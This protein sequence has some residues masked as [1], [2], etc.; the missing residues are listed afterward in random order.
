MDKFIIDGG[1]SLKGTITISGS[2]NASLPILLSTLLTQEICTIHQVPVSRDINTTIRLLEYL[3]KKVER[4]GHSIKVSP[5]RPLKTYAPYDLV[6]QMRASVLVAGPLLARFKKVR[7]P[8]PGGCAIGLR[9]IN[10]HLEGFKALGA[11][12]SYQ[13]GDVILKANRLKGASIKLPFPSVGATENLLMSSVLIPGRTRIQNAAREPEI[14]DLADFL[15]RM[16]AKIRGA[17]K[18]VIHIVGVKELHG[19]WH[20][21]IPDRIEVGTFLI[22]CSATGGDLILE[23]T[24]PEHVGALLK[25]L[26]ACGAVLDIFPNRIRIRMKS[27]PRTIGEIKTE[28]FPG[29]PTDLQAPW[30]TLMCFSRQGRCRIQENI[31]EKRFMHAAELARMGAQISVAPPPAG[32]AKSAPSRRSVGGGVDGTTVVVHGTGH[33]YGAPVMAS[34]IRAGAALI[35]AGL[36]AR[37]RTEISRVYHIDRGY[38]KIEEKL[39]GVGARIKRVKE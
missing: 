27:R 5:R 12:V 26:K 6:K 25:K 7:V 3:G 18:S 22:A 38:E 36:A 21:V 23:G 11:S 28:V 39:Q 35:V 33:L 37:G 14:V 30:M 17:G 16:G 2:K 10:I 34:D 8:L 9:P 15:N 13:K 24:C 32:E 19:A 29:F 31:F 4:L 20:A 1:R